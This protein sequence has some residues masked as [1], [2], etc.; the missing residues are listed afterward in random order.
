M[1]SFN[2]LFKICFGYFIILLNNECAFGQTYNMANNNGQTITTCRAN[3]SSSAF[4][5]ISGYT[6]NEISI[7][8][9][10]SGS[11]STPLRINFLPNGYNNAYFDAETNYDKLEIYDNSTATGTP[12]ATLTGSYSY[13][14]NTNGLFY[15]SNTGYL[16]LRF[17]S[18]NGVR[19]YGF[20]ANI[21]CP[22]NGCNGNIAASDLCASATQICDLNGYCGQTG[23]WYTV[24]RRDIG[25]NF[26]GGPFCGSIE[27]NS[28]ISFV[29]SAATATFD[30]I[31]SNC[32]S[33]SSGV[34]AAVMSTNNCASGAFTLVSN[35]VSQS[36][37]PG[38]FTLTATGLT[39]GQTYFIMI[40][41]YGGN[42]CDYS[43]TAQS[44]VQTVNISSSQGANL[45]PGQNTNLSLTT[46]GAG[47]FTY[48]WSSGSTSLGTSSTINV[49]PTST[50]SYTATVI[51]ACG[52]S[53]TSIYTL[54]VNSPSANVSP[55]S[56]NICPGG[57]VNLTSTSS[58][59]SAPVTKT[60]SS[61]TLNANIPDNNTT[62]VSNSINLSGYLPTLLSSGTLVSVT[63]NITHPYDGD[64]DI[65]LISPGGTTID[66]SSDNGGT[67][68]NYVN[69]IFDPNAGTAITAGGAPF[70]GSF[71][72]EGNFSSIT[73]QNL[74][75]NW[76]LKVAD[77]GPSDI[78]ILVN[79]SITFLLDNSVNSF[80]WSPTSGLSSSTVANP[81]ATPASS[82]TYTL[83]ITDL[84]GCSKTATA[85]VNVSSAVAGGS[86]ATSTSYC[87]GSDPVAL[88]S[89][90]AGSGGT[91]TSGYQWQQSTDGGVT[92]T[93]ITGATSATY[94]P[95]VISSTTLFRRIYSN[96]CGSANSN[97]VTLT[98]YPALNAGTIGSNQTVCNGG[99]PSNLTFSTNASGGN[100]PYNYQWQSSPDN[101]TWTDIAGATT[102]S[103]DHPNGLTSIKYIRVKV[104]DAC[105]TVTYANVITL[106]VYAALSG[107]TIASAQTICSGSIPATISSSVAASG[108]TGATT[109]Q[110][111]SS[112]DGITWTN[113]PGATGATY[114]PASL[115]STT[116]YRRVA[117]NTCGSAN[118]NSIIITVNPLPSVSSVPK[119]DVTICGGNNGTIT[120]NASGSPTL[121][122]SING[123][124]TYQVSNS[125]TNLSQGTYTVIVRDG[126]SCTYSWGQ[127]SI[128]NGS[129]PSAPTATSSV[130]T[131]VCNGSPM[132]TFTVSNAGY[133]YNWW[134]NSGLTTPA[135]GT[136]NTTSY[137]P[138][139]PAAG[140]SATYYVTA[141][142]GGC[143]SAAT[144]FTISVYSNV[145]AGS[146]GSNQTICSGQD[147]VILSELTP[148]S[149]GNSLSGYTYQ[150]EMSTNGGTSWSDIPGATG[151][152]YDPPTL[153]ST[154]L[155]RRKVTNT[156]GTSVTSTITITVN[157]NPT[158][159]AISDVSACP[160][161]TIST[162]SF[163][164]AVVGSTFSWTASGSYSTVG[165]TASSG[166]G[167]IPSW[168]APSNNTGGNFTSQVTVTAT[169]AGCSGASTNFNVIIKPTPLVNSLTD[170]VVC[171]TEVISLGSFSSTP[172]GGSFNW[173][174]NN[175][176]IGIGASGTG[177]ISN[178]NAPSN[179]TGSNITG[180]IS[181]TTTLNGCISNPK[182]VNITIKP[183]PSLSSIS[184]QSYCPGNTI[185][186]QT[187]TST[188]TGATVNWTNSNT[189][190]GISSAGSGNIATWTAPS[191]ASGSNFTGTITATPSLNGCPGT[192]LVY[193]ITIKP[194]PVLDAI[195]DVYACPG[196]SVS[197]PNFNSNPAGT[198]SWSNSNTSIGLGASGSGSIPAFT[199]GTNSSGVNNS[200]SISV[201]AT[202]NGCT[203]SSANFQIFI[204]P[205]PIIDKQTDIAVCPGQTTIVPAFNTN[206][207]GSSFSWTNSNTAIGLGASGNGNIGSFISANNNTGNNIIGSIS[208]TAQNN[209]CQS[210][211]EAFNII[212][213][214]KPS[215]TALNNE[216]FCPNINANIPTFSSTPSGG[217]FN[218]LNDNTSIGLGASGAG[219]IPSFTTAANNSGSNN[220]STIKVIGEVNGC[221][222]D[223]GL[224]TITISPTPALNSLPDISSCP[225]GTL[226]PI[227]F[228]SNP[229]G[230]FVD[231]TNS[232]SS[233]NQPLLGNGNIG[234][235]IAPNN[236]SGSSIV[237]NIIAT[238]TLAGCKGKAD[239]V[240][241]TVYSQ[242]NA[243]IT[244]PTLT[245]CITGSNPIP[246]SIAQ[247]GGTFSISGSAIINSSTGEIDLSSTT[248]GN[249][250]VITYTTNGTCPSTRNYT[251]TVSSSSISADFTISP[252]VCNNDPNQAPVYIN[253]G[254]AGNYTV[255][256]GGNGLNIDPSGVVYVSASTPGTYTIQNTIPA[257]GGCAA[258]SA[259]AT[260]QIKPKPNAGF[261]GLAPQYC[262][263]A[264]N[265][266]LVPNLS[267]G[268]FS[269]NGVSGTI[270]SPSNS[271][272]GLNTITHT[273]SLNGCT[274]STTQIVTVFDKPNVT[275]LAS[276]DTICVGES[277]T[278]NG[279]GTQSY[280]WNN[281]VI[282]GVA[283]NPSISNTYILTGTDGNNCSSTD[284][285][286]IT[287]NAL[288][289]LNTTDISICRGS[290]GNLIVSGNAASYSWSNGQNGSS[291]SVSPNNTATYYVAGTSAEGCI[292]TDSA[293][294][295]VNSL[296][297][298][299][300]SASPSQ[301]CSGNNT[302]ITASGNATSYSWIPNGSSLGQINVTLT[303]DSTFTIVGQLGNCTD[304]ARVSVS[305][306]PNPNVLIDGFP[307]RDTT[308][309]FGANITVNATGAT[310]Y[311]WSNGN[312]TNG[313]SINPTSN[314]SYTVIGNSSG[315]SD[316]AIVNVSVN[317]PIVLNVSNT[318]ICSG[319]TATIVASGASTYTWSNSNTNDTLSLVI[320]SPGTYT[321]TVTGT[322][323]NNCVV[324]GQG[325][326]TVN[327]KPILTVKDTTICSGN[328]ATLTA[329]GAVQYSWNTNAQTPII[330]ISPT[331]NT[332]YTVIGTNQNN[333]SDTAIASVTVNNTPTATINN[334]TTFISNV[335]E[336][337]TVSLTGAGAFF[338][339]WS[340][341]STNTTIYATVSTN[342][343][344]TLT[345]TDAITGCKDTAL[346]F[347]NTITPPN[348]VVNN[349]SI[350][351][352]SV[353]TLIANGGVNY[354]WSDGTIN[355]SLIVS[356]I[357]TSTYTVEGIDI[358]GCKNTAT[359]TVTLLQNPT[360]TA[361]GATIC[362]GETAI[363]S[364]SGNASSYT[365][366]TGTIGFFSLYSN[367]LKRKLYIF[368]YGYC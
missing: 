256:S 265:V 123:G 312:L 244:Y 36:T 162:I 174:N 292:Y 168:T 61:G 224:F 13:T 185:P 102:N 220:T 209:G 156:C 357:N 225:G 335:C 343:I 167:N 70:T 56:S 235:W 316:T 4:G 68:D 111:Q 239:T 144:A 280:T 255:I 53:K 310:T 182:T 9:F 43:V 208:V 101:T 91:G 1:K 332:T 253:G 183:T 142:T 219:N 356:P 171:A 355:D 236:N 14:A 40:D 77:D 350:C 110:W 5:S 112:P 106:N 181:Y 249:T 64:L 311:S 46:V 71:R 133:S 175:T 105:G 54:N 277:I 242:D 201:T 39:I 308:I 288:P 269:G 58:T 365:W 334:Q 79:W 158:V 75:G 161:A 212:V 243:S 176:N 52:S 348:I 315:C 116:Y 78:G 108:G 206:P 3:I 141:T 180:A 124:T 302:F 349:P 22:L 317:P 96:T 285:I 266:S 326:I 329:S 42:I 268:A 213:K 293:L 76:T 272:I 172:S 313:I 331:I 48:S 360:I 223:T 134:S 31:S 283:F 259:T 282:N 196:S 263:N 137:T 12:I 254:T 260:I 233:I 328:S 314:T 291:I 149:G 151:A 333:C 177:S 145:S 304:T 197:V 146:V 21:G 341:G 113:I 136:N 15:T 82:T 202:A 340:N 252:V 276:D 347:I 188:P 127:V 163:N 37:G 16:T 211:P 240:V 241:V 307:A 278:L 344:Y 33:N 164:S 49:S 98:V 125:F 41:G 152:T 114:S 23:G 179:N 166:V 251:L 342:S 300:L 186:N 352:G 143:Q 204:Y 83:T 257:S 155:Y 11:A 84:L 122:Y 214:P 258:D 80:V 275:G 232:N 221:N 245:A 66:L 226:G 205:T 217:Q 7:V 231:W 190:I 194:I 191:N 361:Q 234:S 207:F 147:P 187:F 368:R 67:G 20:S 353:A 238:P 216:T 74:N 237:S 222:S 63:V 62:G 25:N 100:G 279:F 120:I 6:N 93:N 60:F 287:V 35:C 128:T 246:S 8:T 319:N 192:N 306:I 354:Q 121:N 86:I 264:S 57:S 358:N 32:I 10:Y 227:N 267:G 364:V 81:T 109:Y 59:F 339:S 200:A 210:S 131:S 150:W 170:V 129:A 73:G 198:Y 104:T 92:W 107:G 284:T 72:P 55:S 297:G 195:S 126:N 298:T 351:P 346:A 28:W 153:T 17:T 132:P 294:V 159:A 322:D 117:T 320:F 321:Y 157:P 345:V 34:Q 94:D 26:T 189:S 203:G 90:T 115:S 337:G 301:I 366:D 296:P 165:L 50:T 215:L 178:W 97:T 325:V 286:S 27:N 273:I 140:S 103:Y 24:D 229:G 69:T 270:F 45:C 261:T 327:P 99:D 130:N 363:V 148:A 89:T 299:S 184:N 135:S 336:N 274:D 118:S 271:N 262:I 138:S 193:I 18:D 324:N 295:T 247:P 47:P 230:A 359:A 88:T 228:S 87:T 169:A 65:S 250:Y 154:T 218:W 30:V 19:W 95:G 38:L 51:G 173:S 303:D 323:A 199:A 338:T 160:G 362:K 305:I 318:T 330:N 248:A 309:C 85:T 367:C 29:A 44:G 119:T 2:I 289:T 139:A 281:G 290:F